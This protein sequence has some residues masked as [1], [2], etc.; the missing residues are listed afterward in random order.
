[1]DASNK[2]GPAR[3]SGGGRIAW[4]LGAAAVAAILLSLL[5]MGKPDGRLPAVELGTLEDPS[6]RVPLNSLGTQVRVVNFWASWCLPCRIEHPQIKALAARYPGAVVGINYMDTREDARRWLD[7][8]GDPFSLVLT[9]PSGLAGRAAGL[10]G[11]PYT[12]V[13]DGNGKVIFRHAG[14]LDTRQ[15]EGQILPL[16]DP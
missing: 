4:G 6:A 13:L 7:Y 3:A 2:H 8:F 12:L 5:L 15:L 11:V 10:R 1:M 16:L 9:D 14:P